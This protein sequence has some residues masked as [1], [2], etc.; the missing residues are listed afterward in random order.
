MIMHDDPLSNR[1]RKSFA[2]EEKEIVSAAASK[3]TDI[4]FFWISFVSFFVII[5][6]MTS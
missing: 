5:M 3:R 6:G 4:A 2:F 1:F